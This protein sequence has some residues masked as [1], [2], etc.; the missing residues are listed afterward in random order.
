MWCVH[1]APFVSSHKKVRCWTIMNGATAPQAAGAIHGDI[2]KVVTDRVARY[3]CHFSLC[4][5]LI[6]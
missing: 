3:A 5:W 6:K 2:E 1:V 4:S